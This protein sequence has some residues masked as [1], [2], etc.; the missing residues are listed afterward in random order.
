MAV[1]KNKII[2]KNALGTKAT[3]IG[4]SFPSV[5]TVEL[6]GMLNKYD[7]VY[8]DGEH[9]NFTV[10]SISAMC[11]TAEIYDLTVMARVSEISAKE[12]NMYLN[13]GVLGFIFP[14]IKT[15][16]EARNAVNLCKYPP[17]GKRGWSSFSKN[18]MFNDESFFLELNESGSNLFEARKQY[19]K[20][21][22]DEILIILQLESED[23]ISNISE[24]VEIEGIYAYMGGYGDLTVSSDLSQIELDQVVN[25]MEEYIHKSGKKLI[26]DLMRYKM[27]SSF[28]LEGARSFL[29]VS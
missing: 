3:G 7:Y 8:L 2:K 15:A 23:A 17:Q 28:I 13:Q 21:E 6:I 25:K 11:R 19:I 10:D 16:D 27:L 9:G 4:F 1:K 24:I 5:E 12:V 14:N 26:S 29:N 20:N 22:N 18:N